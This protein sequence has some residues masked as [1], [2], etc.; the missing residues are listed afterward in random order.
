MC[1]LSLV[2]LPDGL[3]VIFNRDELR[4]RPVALPPAVTEVAGQTMAYPMDP[5]SGGTWIGTNGAG[6]VLGVLNVSEGVRPLRPLYSRGHII[7]ALLEYERLREALRAAVRLEAWR[8]QPF[9]LVGAQDGWA[10]VLSSNGERLTLEEGPFDVP[11]LFTSSSLGD[12]LVESPRRRLFEQMVLKD[13]RGWLEGQA[14]FHAHQWP[15]HP[16]LS[17]RMSREDA[18]T[19]SRSLIDVN[20]D[21]IRFE[22]EALDAM[23]RA[24]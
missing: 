4:S 12:A 19:L 18:A 20:P 2:P 17:V 13:P 15:N 24:A 7:P 8:F 6:L 21:R 16:E 9:R 14:R 22:Y 1:T 3:R 23:P 5:Q 11:R 10:G